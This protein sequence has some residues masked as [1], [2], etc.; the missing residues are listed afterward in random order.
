[1]SS[2]V[3]EY[4]GTLLL[5]VSLGLSAGS[6]PTGFL[7]TAL[8]YI[9]AGVSGAHFNPAVT[10]AFWAAEGMP[11]GRFWGYIG[12]QFL[13]A[14]TGGFLLFYLT[15]SA[16]QIAPPSTST[17]LQF[18]LI[19]TLF[20]L[21]LALAYLNLFLNEAYRT[22]PIHGIVIGM[23]YTGLIATGSPISGGIFN[24]AFAAGHSLTALLTSSGGSS[25]LTA[26]LLAPMTGGLA[27][28]YLFTFLQ[29]E[30]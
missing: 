23:A 17:P 5:A 8:I 16:F 12:S 28:G 11:A 1:M 14:L 22:F 25:Y 2:Y 9:G 6:L 3:S 13:G 24:P 18:S 27:A 30:S 29:R 4:L 7:L 20:T 19:E 10:I 26:F 21:I 15:E